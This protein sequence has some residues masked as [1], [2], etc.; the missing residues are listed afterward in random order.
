MHKNDFFVHPSAIVDAGAK[1]GAGTKV[2]HFCHLMPGSVIGENCILGQNIY[3]GRNVII[4]NRVKIQNNVS[5]YQGVVVE[6]D[7]FLGP[8]MVFT[9]VINPR[10]FIE[11]KE[12]LKKTLVRR[13]ATVGANATII[14]GIEIGEYALIGAGTVVTKN[15]PSFGLIKGNPGRLCGWVSKAGYTLDFKEGGIAVCSRTGERYRLV[16]G[17]VEIVEELRD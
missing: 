10:S 3:I 7:V 14:C 13:G 4:G 9:N 12:E 1:I 5:V 8:S 11:R 2:W 16:G 6:D 17:R 15:V